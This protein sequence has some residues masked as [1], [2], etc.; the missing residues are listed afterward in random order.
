MY[1]QDEGREN[2]K[3]LTVKNNARCMACLEC[4]IACSQTFYKEFHQDKSCIQIVEENG[5]TVALACDQCGKCAEACP[6][7]AIKVNARGVYIVNKRL[8]NRCGKCVEACP[9]HV[10]I[11]PE[12]AEIVSKCAGCGV[13][14]RVCPMEILE[15]TE[16]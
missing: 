16:Y 13:C 12:G 1:R 3:K 6:E 9:K 10:C 11:L 8:C 5:E 2:V 14:V 7:G 4:V 15:I